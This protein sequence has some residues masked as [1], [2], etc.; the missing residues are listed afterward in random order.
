MQIHRQQPVYSGSRD[1][2]CDQARRDWHPRC[3]RP[4][5]LA[6]IAKIR[7]DRGNSG[8]R[9]ATAGVCHNQQFHEVVVDRGT[10]GLED[11]HIPTPDVLQDFD[12]DLSITEAAHLDL[13]HG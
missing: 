6:C 2:A 7:N 5:V 10:G 9:S 11:K 3:T 4:A 8:C 13:S 1:H 12:V